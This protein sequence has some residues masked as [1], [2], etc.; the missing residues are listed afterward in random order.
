MLSLISQVNWASDL[1]TQWFTGSGKQVTLQVHLFTVSTCP[2]CQ[3]AE[4]FLND[5]AS[6]NPWLDIHHYVINTDKQALV[7]FSQFLKGQQLNDFSVPAIF[8]C[9]SRWVG[10][11]DNEKS[12]AQL[13][14]GLNYC[15]EQISKSGELTPA[16][17]QTLKQMALANWYEGSLTTPPSTPSFIPLMAIVDALN[18][19]AT[20]L[21]FALIAFL[22]SL[23]TQNKRAVIL[24]SFALGAGLA[25]YF[26]F[27]HLSFFYTITAL[28]RP[29]AI[30]IGLGLM[31]FILKFV[32]KSNAQLV[33]ATTAILVFFTALIIQSYIQINNSP[34][35]ALIVKQWLVSQQFSASKQMFYQ[36][37]YIMTYVITLAL[38][39]L[40]IVLLFRLKRLQNYLPLFKR[41]GESFL[42]V[43]GVFLIA[44]PYQ[45]NR[46]SFIFIVLIL[47][48]LITWIL[49]KFYVTKKNPS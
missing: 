13:L 39:A 38:D 24:I 20:I 40:I 27:A 19:S 46:L 41:L 16:T 1:S 4:A 10:F 18:P 23:P 21:V 47:T 6:K 32:K 7:T 28:L 37:I 26:Q 5:L 22:I 48:V 30:L 33:I 31:I 44:Y 3:K 43:V 9:D 12:G 15:R 25:H 29:L 42:L 35:F 2:Y 14:A 34:N 49:P 11:K 17:V 36:L 8:F 45:L